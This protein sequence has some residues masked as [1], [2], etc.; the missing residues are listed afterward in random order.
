MDIVSRLLGRNEMSEG[1][2]VGKLTEIGGRRVLEKFGTLLRALAIVL[3]LTSLISLPTAYSAFPGENGKIAFAGDGEIYVME[4][5]GSNPANL[6]NNIFFDAAPA[7][8]PD[9]TKI[10][11]ASGRNTSDT[12]GQIY[13]MDAD[14][15]DVIRLTNNSF[16]DSSPAWSPDGAR[17]VF[18]RGVQIFVMD[19]DGMNEFQLTSNT[20]SVPAWSPGGTEI[21]FVRGFTNTN[22]EIF[23]ISAIGGTPEQLTFNGVNS[24]FPNWSPDGTEIAFDRG[25]AGTAQIWRM[26]ADGMN[27][28]QIT[29]APGDQNPAWSPDGTKIAFT[30]FDFN[31]ASRPSD[32]YVMNANGSGLVNLTNNIVFRAGSP[33]WQPLPAIVEVSTL[34]I[35]EDSIGNGIS[36]NFF[37]G[38]DVNDDIAD[39]G[40]R[41]LLPAFS[42]LNVGKK[43]DLHTGEVG[44]EGWFAFTSV[45]ESWGEDG[46]LNFV[47]AGPG[48]G[49]PD[50][51]GDRE[52]LLDK[53][54]NVTPLRATGLAALKGKQVCAVV[55]DSDISINYDDPLNASLKGANLGVVALEVLD[56]TAR[57]DGSSSSLPKVTVKVLDASQIC[58]QSLI[59][60]EDA[61]IPTSSSE[62]LD[63]IPSEAGS[64][65]GG[66]RYGK[67][68]PPRK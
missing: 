27:Q 10:A 16:N 45:P 58:Q 41:D 44:D 30:R 32:I 47:E 66:G 24:R 33:D 6:P 61:P 12:R 53:V 19:A 38:P 23:K 39:I 37:P 31:Q 9:G 59:L 1:K 5:D 18:S 21:A 57:T 63:V 3:L 50:A 60:F 17:I 46:L 64:G 14:G 36:P 15:T 2:E 42:G 67:S 11:F 20:G 4:P 40:L 34:V 25:P 52:A 65:G 28:V 62:P 29:S 43:Y 26:D 68:N 8:S 48:L 51:D 55:F 35:D 56:V 54:P 49:S 7:C 22:V 13:V